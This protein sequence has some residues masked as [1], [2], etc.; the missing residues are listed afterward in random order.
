MRYI[1]DIVADILGCEVT[2]LRMPDGQD[3]DDEDTRHAVEEGLKGRGNLGR[4][5]FDRL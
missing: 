1:Y 2:L 5:I 3:S 4:S